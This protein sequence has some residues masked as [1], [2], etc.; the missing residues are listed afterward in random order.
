MILLHSPLRRSSQEVFTSFFLKNLA[1]K[2]SLETFQFTSVSWQPH[3]LCPF[4]QPF[5]FPKSPLPKQGDDIEIVRMSSWIPNPLPPN[6]FSRCQV[7]SEL[8]PSQICNWTGK[9][10]V[11]QKSIFPEWAKLSFSYLYL[12][13]NMPKPMVGLVLHATYFKSHLQDC[14]YRK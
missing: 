2:T 12:S 5:L 7:C 10:T 8:F 3:M 9:K 11:R 14:F 4:P 6:C 13:F 1:W